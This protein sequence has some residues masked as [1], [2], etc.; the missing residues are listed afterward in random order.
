[1]RYPLH[2]LDNRIDVVIK[3]EEFNAVFV[4]DRIAGPRI[5]IARLADGAR[6]DDALLKLVERIAIV[7]IGGRIKIGFVGEQ[8]GTVGMTDEALV[9]DAIE[10]LVDLGGCRKDVVGKDVLIDG[11]PR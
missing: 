4:Q 10:D 2:F 3:P 6:I 8:T 1:M 9:V 5:P 11:S 7:E